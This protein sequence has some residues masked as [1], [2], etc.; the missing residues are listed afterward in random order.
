[1]VKPR[2]LL[3]GMALLGVTLM[4]HAHHPAG[5][6][7]TTNDVVIARVYTEDSDRLA[8][9]RENHLMLIYSWRAGYAVIKTDR[10]RLPKDAVIDHQWTAELQRPKHY[11]KMGG[12]T[13]PARPCYRTVEQTYLDL[14]AIATGNPGLAQWIDIGDSWEKQQGLGGYDIHALVLS[15]QFIA[16]PKPVYMVMSAVH[17]RELATAESATRFAEMLIDGYGVD[18]DITWMLDYYE[19]HVLAQQNPDGRKMA[20]SECTGSCFP[21]WRKNTNQDYC[22][23]TS[24]DRGADLNRNGSGTFW[25]GSSSSGSQCS[26]TYRGPS[27]ASE[28]ETQSVES[29]AASVFPDYRTE[30]PGDLTTPADDDADGIFISIHSAGDIV[31]YPWEGSNDTPPNLTGLRSLAQK[32]GF[33][34]TFAACQNCFLG[35]ASGT[36]VDNVF[37]KLGVPAFTYEIGSSFGQSCTSFE[38]TVLP[39]TLAGLMSGLKHTRRPY[40]SSPGPDVI[41][42]SVQDAGA[43]ALLSVTADDTRRSVNGGGE[44]VETSHT[45]QSV[46]FTVGDPPWIAAQS[47]PLNADDGA[48]DES[49]EQASAM[50]AGAQVPGGEN[51]VFVYAVDSNGD[52]GPPSALFVNLDG[53]FAD[54]L[55]SN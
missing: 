53:I 41:N 26:E 42:L 51:I 32:M 37:E 38:N 45:I 34:T 6:E 54:G 20:E 40:Q 35:P 27:P 11:V 24:D 2:Q 29:Y 22:G 19:V 25:G 16:G 39:Q 47:F 5:P 21:G 48:F 1:M 7:P 23:T 9:L 52:Q 43:F 3:I 17:A 49:S 10:S 33:S 50:I 8:L 13:I 31:F 46:R 14:Q 30:S 28:P 18:A 12:A 44:P 4:A 15:N 55:E 36:N